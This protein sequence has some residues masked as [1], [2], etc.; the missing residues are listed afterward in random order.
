MVSASLPL[1]TEAKRVGVRIAP[2]FTAVYFCDTENDCVRNIDT[3]TGI[4][5]T[6]AGQGEAPPTVETM[7]RPARPCEMDLFLSSATLPETSLLQ[8][9]GAIV[10]DWWT[11]PVFAR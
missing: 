3:A 5:T 8:T 2:S 9:L 1:A 10:S 7:D 11:R 6:L 4:I